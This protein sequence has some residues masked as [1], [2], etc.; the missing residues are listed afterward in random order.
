MTDDSGPAVLAGRGESV[1][2]ALKAV[3][4]VR[5]VTRPLYPKR[6]VVLV[7]AHFALGHLLAPLRPRS[8][9]GISPVGYY[10]NSL[11]VTRA[12][13]LVA[14]FREEEERVNERNLGDQGL[15]VSELGLGCMGMSEFYGTTDED[16]SIATIHRAIELGVTLLDTADMYGPFTN[17]R[18]VG[19]A[20]A[21]R[22]DRVTLA[23]KFGNERREDGSWIG[24]NG[25]PEYVSSACDASLERLGVDYIDLYYQHRIDPEVPVEETVGAMKE[26]VEAGKVRYLGLSEAAPETIR[27]ANSEH[28]ISALQSE[29]SLF[30]RDVEGEILPTLRELASVSSPTA[31]R[32]RFPDRPL[33]KPR[34]HAGE[35]HP[36]RQIPALRGGEFSQ[37][38]GARGQGQVNR[39]REGCGAGTARPR[40]AATPG[41]RH[42]THPWYQTTRAPGGERRRSERNT[43][44][45]GLKAHRGDNPPWLGR[46]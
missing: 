10:R 16:E 28:S 32:V 13:K 2:R 34:G 44:Q 30:T 25:K 5:L 4:H 35:R 42:S 7:A 46:R 40:L 20:I 27:R 45:R 29:Y 15:V 21:D 14:D 36:C 37:E 9:L 8:S 41:R 22:R 19:K 6:L 31:P 43:H 39:R 18:L 17:E 11:A 33:E 38:P 12:C 1:D 24:V 3:E 26:L 23:T